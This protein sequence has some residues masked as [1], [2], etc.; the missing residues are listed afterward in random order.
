MWRNG[1]FVAW[2]GGRAPPFRGGAAGETFSFGVDARRQRVLDRCRVDRAER[3]VAQR[4]G[5]S[6]ASRAS[7]MMAILYYFIE[8]RDG[9][10]RSV[11]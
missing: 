1:H 7:V 11:S 5:S 2:S 6:Q 8:A 10:I 4:D 9:Q 3:G